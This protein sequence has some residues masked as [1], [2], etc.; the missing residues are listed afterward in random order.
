MSSV[1]IEDQTGILQPQDIEKL[2][3][4]IVNLYNHTEAELGILIMKSAD[5][6]EFH[7]YGVEIFNSEK[8]RPGKN[9][10]NNGIL[11]IFFISDRH[12]ELIPGKG[13]NKLFPAAFTKNLFNNAVVPFMRSNNYSDGI[14]SG[15][16]AVAE[17]IKDYHKQN[18]Q[19]VSGRGFYKSRD[20]SPI[21]L[22]FILLVIPLLLFGLVLFLVSNDYISFPFNGGSGHNSYSNSS[23]YDSSSYSDSNSDSSF[24]SDSSSDSGGS[25]D[26]GGG[27][28][29]DW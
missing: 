11:I 16:N 6:A 15:A 25:A 24:S 17:V 7:K 14:I 22:L 3:T 1:K 12:V 5:G 10:L 28:G 19:P 29:T 26:G 21:R 20:N 23:S 9:E 4:V 2:K 13:Y 18:I 8:W 27:G